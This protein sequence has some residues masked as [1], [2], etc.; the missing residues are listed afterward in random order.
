M[1]LNCF[2]R[3]FFVLTF[4]LANKLQVIFDTL[5]QTT[6]REGSGEIKLYGGDASHYV[7]TCACTFILLITNLKVACKG[8]D[9]KQNI[10]DEN[11]SNNNRDNN[12][13][14]DEPL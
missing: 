13:G 12:D 9:V 8:G 14:K 3:I 6:A 5:T 2:N 1:R 10:D 4:V 7:R 11:S